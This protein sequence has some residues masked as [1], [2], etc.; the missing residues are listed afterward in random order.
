MIGTIKNWRVR[1]LQE[2]YVAAVQ[3]HRKYKENA[4]AR[5]RRGATDR[6]LTKE[7]AITA[8]KAAARA[9]KY[10]AKLKEIGA[11]NG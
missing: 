7:C 4:L 9:N 1:R 11:Y 5:E 10:A 3:E 8:G 6:A 2:K